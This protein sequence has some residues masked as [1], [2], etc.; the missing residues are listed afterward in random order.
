MKKLLFLLIPACFFAQ[1]NFKKLDSLQFR[2]N[3]DQ[4]VKDTGRNYILVTDRN[5]DDSDNFMYVNS[6][7]KTDVLLVKY[8]TYMDGKNN[9]LEIVGVKKWGIDAIY[10]KYLALF[11]LWKKHIDN[12]AD[13]E[14]SSK[15]SYLK[16]NDVY[17]SRYD[18]EGH[19]KI[20]F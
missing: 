11:P 13:V 1:T 3:V 2:Q 7:D 17:M 15:K 18:N 8:F 12:K 4:L 9:D 19:W 5:D 16:V 10:G 20:S 14:L 6:E